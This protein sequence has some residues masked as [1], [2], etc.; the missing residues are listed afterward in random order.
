M[1]KTSLRYFNLLFFTVFTLLVF[2]FFLPVLFPGD[3][4]TNVSGITPESVEQRQAL[5][6]AF[7][8]DQSVFKQ[9]TQYLVNLWEGNW[10]VSTITQTPLTEE[11][12]SVFPATLELVIYA[13]LIAIVVGIPVGMLAGLKHHT[14][15]DFSVVSFS[16]VGYSFPVFWLAMIFIT[17]FCLGNQW[18]PMSGR[19]DLL[20]DVP[21]LTG[22]ILIDILLSDI[23]FKQEAFKNAVMHLILPT[24]SV[25]I[26]TMALF[27]RFVRRSMMDVMTREY[28][29][30]AK[31]RGFSRSQI[32]LKHGVKN[33][34]IPILPI[35]ALQVSTLITNVMIVETIFSWPGI[36]KWL[37]E[38]IYQQDYPAIR[39]GMLIVSLFVMV[40][41]IT[42]EFLTRVLDPAR[43]KVEHATI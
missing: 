17:V 42:T 41:T 10:G 16:I 24:A 39:M 27:T 1:T 30:A 21:H 22:F 34:L 5:V 36:G 43:E 3:L 19:I 40:L 14:T 20:F 28:I 35:L 9:F 23:E 11:I 6:Q 37:I 25:A 2:S 4:I 32:V 13:L 15:F 12:K 8:Y 38:A 7:A 29:V 26:V 31:S 33:S 18:L